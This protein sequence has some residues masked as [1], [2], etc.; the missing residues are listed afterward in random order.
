MTLFSSIVAVVL[1]AALSY[2]LVQIYF[3]VTKR[4]GIPNAFGVACEILG[5]WILAFDLWYE[6]GMDYAE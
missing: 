4:L 6:R 3:E 5:G 1:A 2:I